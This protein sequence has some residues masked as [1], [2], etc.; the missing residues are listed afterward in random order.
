MK[1]HQRIFLYLLSFLLAD[2]IIVFRIEASFA[3]S[4]EPVGLER[5]KQKASLESRNISVNKAVISKTNYSQDSAQEEISAKEENNFLLLSLVVHAIEILGLFA[6]SS[7][8]FFSLNKRN[9]KNKTAIDKLYKQV[10]I[11]EQKIENLYNPSKISTSSVNTEGNL[12][13]YLGD[14]KLQYPQQF[15]AKELSSAVKRK[16]SA[17]EI[18]SAKVNNIESNYFF[19]D[20][21][22][23][24]FE[25]FKDKYS[26]ILVSEDAEGFGN[27]WSG[28]QQE[29]I[30]SENQRG[31]YWIFNEANITY[32]I[33]KPR[34]KLND[35]N[36]YTAGS[37]FECNSY[38]PDYNHI[39]IARPAI[40]SFQFGSTQ[41]WKLE[42]NG[43]LE[44]T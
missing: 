9:R 33:P 27:R 6:L 5:K 31:N 1:N 42:K 28:K 19:L 29:I 13:L 43:V 38:T 39:I 12:E 24:S 30:L 2:S 10:K 8:L 21:Y 35:K 44:F 15:P 4:A 32:L 7:Y 17:K 37:L 22:Y 26:P 11:Q 20:V 16:A 18:L 25:R 3:E 23:Q 36:M 14:K 40:V 41:K 34:L